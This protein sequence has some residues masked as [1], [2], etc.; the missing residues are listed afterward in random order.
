MPKVDVIKT[1][2]AGGEFG[3]SLLGRSDMDQ[4]ANA[5]A[6]VENWLVRPYGSII[7][8]PGTWLIEETKHSEAGTDSSVRLIPFIFNKDDAYVI[9][10]GDLYFRFY[11][12]RGQVVSDS[13]IEL[14]HTYTEDE[15]ADI[16][17]AQKNDVIY[18]AHA[19]K[20]PQKLIRSSAIDW[21]IEDFEFK[22]G[23]FL[24]DNTSVITINPSAV[25]G[26]SVTLTL[27]ATNSTIS[28]VA[29]SSSTDLGHIGTFWKIGGIVTT[30]TTALQGYV[31][32]TAVS[33][34]TDATCS[35]IKTL[36][37]SAATDNWAE[38]AWSD[39]RGWP[40]NV[41][42]YEARLNFAR[43]DYEPQGVWGS[44]QFVY[45]DFSLNEQNDD[46]GINQ[47][48]SSNQS[49]EIQWLASGN[50]LIAGT[51]GGA[52][53]ING[54]GSVL[55]PTTFTAKQEISVGSESIQPKRIGNFFYYVQ[56]FGKKIRE[57]FYL[58]DNDSYKAMDKTI[59]NP[60]VTGDEI[61]E[62]AYQEVPD[63]ILWCLRSDGQIATLTREADQLVEGWARQITDGEYESICCI[64]SQSH[65]YDEV[66]VV[67]KRTIDGETKRYIEVFENIDLPDRQDKL[68]YLHSALDYD[69]YD[70]TDTEDLDIALSGTDGT[71]NITATGAYFE[72]D[73]IGNRIRAID[74]D[75]NTLGELKITAYSQSTI[76]TGT[77]TYAFDDTDYEAGL[78]GVSVD[79]LS[80]L[81]HLEAKT[82][83][84]L[85]DGGVDKPDKVVS[86]GTIDLAYNYFVI[87]VGLPYTQ[88]LN[89]LPF[90]A[91][92][93]RGTAQG[94][95]QK[96]NQVMFKL[97][98]S[99]RGFKMGG[100]EDLAERV[101]FREPSTLLGTPEALLTGILPNIN[102]KDDYRYGSQIMIINDEPFPI[103]ILSIM[104]TLETFDK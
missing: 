97:N 83:K 3:A 47:K 14:A 66:W 51:Y 23:P 2:F 68:M 12:D 32:I 10:M 63:T 8:T 57:L 86:E 71:I 22:G 41:T 53:I 34:P 70:D 48:L 87:S 92:S 42:F 17:Y 61:I 103:E 77:V 75:G 76:V 58:W 49:N 98:R 19:D 5:C 102:F 24:D 90:E 13:T 67:V 29:S 6:T 100:D 80:G 16:K 33:S 60:E 89:L 9:E 18:M 38:G 40:A 7:S 43:T 81:D 15:I 4:Y 94:K 35:V 79:G 82:V 93:A 74:A 45:D 72:E 104:A 30:A 101:S 59:F 88:K 99:Y 31:E 36:S 85:A 21:T 52:F 84:V 46:E 25:S 62:I 69:A 28:F 78:W 65:G 20:R 26:T 50:S 44:H 55:T 37:A 73:D 39:V 91:G 27:S 1:S 96:I 11:T 56:R 64:P 95:I 54:G